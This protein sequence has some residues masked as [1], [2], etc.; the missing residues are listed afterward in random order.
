MRR[1]S[2]FL[3][4]LLFSSIM[5][6]QAEDSR[7]VKDRLAAFAAKFGQDMI[8]A[9][10]ILKPVDHPKIVDA[11][12]GVYAYE[13]PNHVQPYDMVYDAADVILLTATGDAVFDQMLIYLE[14]R[15]MP[16]IRLRFTRALC[17]IANPR[18]L[19]VLAKMAGSEKDEMVQMELA[20]NLA[21]FQSD[22]ALLTLYKLAMKS[23]SL[24]V[25]VAAV[26]SLGECKDEKS[27]ELLLKL[28][29]AATNAP[30]AVRGEALSALHTRKAVGIDDLIPSAIEDKDPAVRMAAC[31]IA[32][33][34]NR[35][36]LGPKIIAN[37]SAPEWQLRSAAV[38]ACGKLKL[39]ESVGP[40]IELWKKEKGRIEE[41][42]HKALM[43]ITG[44]SFPPDVRYWENW[45]KNLTEP[46]APSDKA[47]EYINYHGIKTKSKNLAFV[48]DRSGSMSEKVKSK[49][50]GYVGEGAV[51]KDDTKMA[52]VKAELIRVIKSLPPDTRF[53]IVAFDDQIMSW[54]KEQTEAAPKVKED[55]IKWVDALSPR[56]TT[57]IYD[58]LCEAFGRLTPGGKVNTEYKTGPDTIFLLTDGMPN[59]GTISNPPDII[60]NITQLNRIRQV[61]IHTIG[62][63]KLCELFLK[64]LADSNNGTYRMIAE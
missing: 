13:D 32:A 21:R 50:D 19:P 45:F 28:Y 44:K 52:F 10:E 1:T 35:S 40:L 63:G 55:A 18:S 49:T 31:S 11:I 17:K 34:T 26:S 3:V 51:V 25:S 24:N 14:V 7:D 30:G 58:A 61:A 48:I 42:I 64:P 22:E 4:L 54:K 62:V 8:G 43:E 29:D 16:R 57:D 53:N 33:D 9:L 37:L 60:R 39:T 15:R 56:G 59:T 5:L 6:V 20:M 38:K 46:L 2:L 23:L 47:G 41:D 12:A 36:E 27:I